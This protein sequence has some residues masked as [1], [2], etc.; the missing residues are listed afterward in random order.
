M[1][2]YAFPYYLRYEI[3]NPDGNRRIVMTEFSQIISGWHPFYVTIAGASATLLGLLFV[4]VSINR[5]HLGL[6][7]NAHLM[8]LARQTFIRYLFIL[9]FSLTMLVPRKTPASLCIP[10]ISLGLF[11]LFNII[12]QVSHPNNGV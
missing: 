12:T 1:G 7:E 10:I 6:D 9:T 11:G 4:T 2:N 5:E 3:F 8:S